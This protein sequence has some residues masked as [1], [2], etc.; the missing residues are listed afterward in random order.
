V[1]VVEPSPLMRKAADVLRGVSEEV[2]VI[3]ALALEA[4]LSERD[5]RSAATTDLDGAVKIG[6]A[7]AV[8]SHLEDAGLEPSE[9]PH[10]RGFTWVR[11]GLKIQLVRPPAP[12]RS[13]PVSGLVTNTHLSV[14]EKYHENV[15]FA[16]RPDEPRLVVARPAAV[17]ALKGHA[18]GRTR[19]GGAL[20]E[21]D[22][23]DAY[24]LMDHVGEEIAAEYNATDD[25]QLRGLIRNAMKD[26]QSPEAR[27][28]VRNQIVQLEPDVSPREADVRL[29]RAIRTFEWR[30]GDRALGAA[31]EP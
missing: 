23:H 26:L 16:E 25:G 9:E 29:T 1:K 15:A 2:V 8:I 24:L 22:Y 30:L 5:A 31:D 13:P 6:S 10:E 27:Q 12:V 18:F 20:V 7:A 28:A 19:P 21:R 17:L 11:D 4:A 14:A 3:G